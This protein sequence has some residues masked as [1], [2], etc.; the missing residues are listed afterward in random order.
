L[1]LQ[2]EFDVPAS[3]QATLELLL[4]PARVVPCI[5]GA[6][7]VEVAGDGTWKTTMEVR[8]GPVGMDFRND[9]RVVENDTGAGTVRLGVKGRDTR[10]RGGADASVDARLTAIDGGGTRV[11]MSADVKFSGQAAQLGR[12][13]VIQDVSTRLVDQFAQCVR[14]QLGGAA[15][16]GD[17]QRVDDGRSGG[18]PAQKP[19]SGLGLL[20][21]ATRGVLA[22]LLHLRPGI[23]EKGAP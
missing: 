21:A 17:E 12:P 3:P 4:D 9:V 20:A 18:L 22:R 1:N 14:D 15:S 16:S 11:T 6:T 19:V 7:L 10:G 5:P 23:R 13:S 2:H 8:L